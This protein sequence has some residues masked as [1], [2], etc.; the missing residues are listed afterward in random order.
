MKIRC[1]FEGKL[2]APGTV[3]GAVRCDEGA[4]ETLMLAAAG[5]VPAEWLDD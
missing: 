5:C 4:S 1:E 2:A 3:K